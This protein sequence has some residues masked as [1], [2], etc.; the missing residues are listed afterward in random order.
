MLVLASNAGIQLG[1]RIAQLARDQAQKKLH[2]APVSVEV[3]I[4]NREGFLVGHAPFP[5]KS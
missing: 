4:I 3:M 5:E 2:D 1:D